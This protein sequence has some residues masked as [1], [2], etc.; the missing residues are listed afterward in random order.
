M[1]KH[2][3][4]N[5]NIDKKISKEQLKKQKLLEKMKDIE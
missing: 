5:Y 4:F 2:T 1:L 3:G